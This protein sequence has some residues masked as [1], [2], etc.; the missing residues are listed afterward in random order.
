V[1]RCLRG[2]VAFIKT[3]KTIETLLCVKEA[4]QSSPEISFSCQT[5]Y[6][7][8]R[9]DIS[10]LFWVIILHLHDTFLVSAFSFCTEECHHHTRYIPSCKCTNNRTH[11][12]SVSLSHTYRHTHKLK[13]ATRV[14][15]IINILG[16]K[17]SKKEG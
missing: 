12:L 1:F 4:V 5:H 17:R 10:K 7:V 9:R 13:C 2:V 3:P 11:S 16:L 14:Y 15:N 8:S 6:T